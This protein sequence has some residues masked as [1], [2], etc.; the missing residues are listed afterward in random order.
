M[1]KVIAKIA[2]MF[3]GGEKRV[4]ERE[5]GGRHSEG[6]AVCNCGASWNHS[7]EPHILSA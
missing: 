1:H 6:E 7:V 4:G 5:K 2:R 3:F